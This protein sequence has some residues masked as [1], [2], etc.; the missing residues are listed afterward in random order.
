MLTD[1][2]DY[3]IRHLATRRTGHRLAF[4]YANT[5]SIQDDAGLF[6][7][8]SLVSFESGCDIARILA[9]EPAIF[10]VAYAPRISDRESLFMSMPGHRTD[11]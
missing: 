4:L 1:H 7:S 3:R 6:T 10:L 2:A 9:I 5:S 11:K 8:R